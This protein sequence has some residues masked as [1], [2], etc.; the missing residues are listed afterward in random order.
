VKGFELAGWENCYK[1]IA[2][3]ISGGDLVCGGTKPS[4]SAFPTPKKRTN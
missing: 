4:Y 3:I 1:G 2:I